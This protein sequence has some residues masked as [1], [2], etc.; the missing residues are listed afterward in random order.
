MTKKILIACGGT[1]GHL[2][3]GIA[4]AQK[5]ISRGHRCEMLISQKQVDQRLI[6]KYPELTFHNMPAVA[7]GKT[8]SALSPAGLLRFTLSQ[9]ASIKFCSK[10][11]KQFRPD[12]VVGF[13]GFSSVSAGLYAGSHRIPLF[14]HEANYRVGRSIRTLANFA[15]TIYLPPG[16]R[17]HQ[18]NPKKVTHLG[19]PLRSDLPTVSRAEARQALGIPAEGP[20][21]VIMGGSQGSS[22]LN[23]WA[24]QNLTQLQ[25][26]GVHLICLTGLDKAGGETAPTHGPRTIW[27]PFSDQMH[28]LYCAADLVIA[29]A[30]AGTIAELVHFRTPSILVP[31]P[32]AADHHQHANA[33][34]IAH[35]GGAAVVDEKEIKNLLKETLHLLEKPTRLETMREHLAKIHLGDAALRICEDIEALGHRH[36]KHTQ[37]LEG[38]FLHALQRKKIS[39][40][41]I[42]LAFDE[43]LGPKTT[44]GIGGPAR[45]YAEPT[46]EK[47][48]LLLLKIAR[49]QRLPWF[50]LGRGSNLLVLDTGFSGLVLRLNHPYWQRIEFQKNNRIKA[51]AGVRLKALCGETCKLGLPGFE[52]MEGIPATLGGALHMNAGAFNAWTF[53]R[54]ER[55]AFLTP[56]GRLKIATPAQLKP[57]Y[58]HVPGLKNA[59]VLWALLSPAS[60][61]GVQPV[62]QV[63]EDY[64]TKRKASQPREAS[65]GC[66]FKNPSKELGAGKAIDETGLKGLSVGG[67]MVSPVHANFIVNKGGATSADVIALINQVRQRVW[68]MKKI[69]LEPEIMLLGGERNDYLISSRDE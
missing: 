4:L 15:R 63:M 23:D 12:V 47:E 30:G 35:M 7:L 31:Y 32:F 59:V 48:L 64:Q 67:A 6:Q 3:P 58:R 56:Q 27:M 26:E 57:A 17:N 20:L 18:L 50:C 5:L 42:K 37:D 33:Q 52:F 19:M 41:S 14:L 55:V 13:G 28:L 44:F 8:H 16:L 61:R 36:K 25:K 62:R 29:R 39:P 9:I 38:T 1:G 60:Q 53:D 68:E 43:P 69:L 40:E 45:V 66:I 24:R 46:N 22:P 54:V 34:H 65:A 11:F 49:R 10:I 21:L 2:A 51:W